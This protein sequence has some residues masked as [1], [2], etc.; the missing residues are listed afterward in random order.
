MQC[1]SALKPWGAT[2]DATVSKP[3]GWIAARTPGGSDIQIAGRL[4]DGFVQA[5]RIVFDDPNWTLDRTD[6][7]KQLRNVCRQTL[8][9]RDEGEAFRLGLVRTSRGK[10]GLHTS[11]VF[12][13]W[14]EREP[15]TRLVV[16]GDSLSDTGKMRRTLKLA[17]RQP[18]WLG[19]F[20]NG[21]IWTDYLEIATGVAVQNHAVG[22]AM[23]G[24]RVTVGKE[25]LGSRIMSNGQFFVSGSIDQQIENYRT[26]YLQNM[27]AQGADK[28]IAV[29][30]GGA[31][32]YISKEAFSETI[33]DLLRGTATGEGYFDV[34]EKVAESTR[35]QVESLLDM[36]MSRVLI[37]TLPDLGMTPMVLHNESY[38]ADGSQSD[39]ERRL[40]LSTRL[41]ELT[42]QHN[43]TLTTMAKQLQGRHPA[44]ALEVL[45]ANKLLLDVIDPDVGGAIMGFELLPQAQEL[46]GKSFKTFQSSCY[47]GVTLGL[48][49][50]EKNVCENAPRAVFWDLVHPSSFFHCWIAYSIGQ[51]L[52][53]AG[54][55]GAQ[56]DKSAYRAWC[57]LIADSF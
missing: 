46:A 45:D 16:F 47:S 5:S 17:P 11:F 36:G 12:D 8:F 51:S 40:E 50:S 57:E 20:S 54:W 35:R 21:P 38:R 2:K 56:R 28:T 31:N 15:A 33:N 34:V 55:I 26:R 10:D 41:S 29:I 19:R 52:H 49:A 22:G 37:I 44:A 9:N 4:E 18:Y 43:Q 24:E 48:F 6:P 53:E 23:S 14:A 32:D 42:R 7:Y 13:E 39:I 27:P 3:K 30:W 1:E 25:E